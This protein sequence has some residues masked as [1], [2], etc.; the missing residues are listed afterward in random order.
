MSDVSIIQ[1]FS[2]IR[3][4]PENSL[5]TFRFARRFQLA[6]GGEI[7]RVTAPLPDYRSGM[8]RSDVQEQRG[9]PSQVTDGQADRFTPT[10]AQ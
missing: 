8:L 6:D 5:E 7:V 10:G 3:T 1:N 2:R 4:I 9:Y